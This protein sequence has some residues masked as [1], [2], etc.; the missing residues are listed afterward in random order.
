[1]ATRIATV[2]FRFSDTF[3]WPVIFFV[4]WVRD[5]LIDKVRSSQANIW[6]ILW[7]LLRIH[8]VIVGRSSLK[9]VPGDR[10]IFI[11]EPAQ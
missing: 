10:D 5:E 11:R 8:S 9:H 1:M 3:S 7:G 6:S 2:T 4:G